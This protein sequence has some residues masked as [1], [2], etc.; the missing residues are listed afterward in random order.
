MINICH[1]CHACDPSYS[2][3]QGWT[4]GSRPD[5]NTVSSRTPGQLRETPALQQKAKRG[6]GI[7][8][9][10]R[11]CVTIMLEPWRRFSELEKGKTMYESKTE[12]G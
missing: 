7:S 12:A 9:S 1:V 4:T 5:C 8:L 2:G 6:L 11:K 3:S 10:G